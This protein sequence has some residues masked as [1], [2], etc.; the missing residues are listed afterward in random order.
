MEP[1]VPGRVRLIT[2]PEDP[3]RNGFARNVLQ[4]LL[5]NPKT[6]P[7]RYFYDQEGS[8]LFERI[9]ELPEYYLTRAEREILEASAAEIAHPCAPGTRLVELG[10]GSASKT[11][12]LIH[13]LVKRHGWLRY[14]PVDISRTMLEE[15][16]RS[17]LRDFPT[18]RIEAISGEYQEGLRYLARDSTSPKL[19][20]WLGSNMGNLDRSESADFLGKVRETLTEGDRMLIGLDLR[21]D[22]TVLERAYDDAQGVTARFNKNLLTRIN[23]EL[24]GRFDL[25]AFAHRAMYDDREGRVDMYLVS[26]VDQRVRIESLDLDLEFR[27]GETIHTESSYKYSP[28]EIQTVS[29]SAGLRVERSWFDAERRF[30]LSLHARGDLTLLALE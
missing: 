20:L 5:S 12:I 26:R 29:E 27:H 15:S 6:L 3:R 7:C 30:C 17:L 9:C 1:K 28:E 2:L 24:G 11:R 18:L 19:V 4:G 14:I 21:K 10:S 25:N 13:E 8:L 23:R 16:S 22:R